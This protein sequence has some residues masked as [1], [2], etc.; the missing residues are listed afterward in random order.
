MS[1]LSKV[2]VVYKKGSTVPEAGEEIES[3]ILRI[4]E[5]ISSIRH[6]YI[7][8]GFHLKEIYRCKYHEKLGYDNFEEFCLCN[9]GMEKS[10]VSR[11]L[12]VYEKF[13]DGDEYKE[14]GQKMWIHPKYKDYSY[15]QLCEMVSMKPE[16]LKKVKPDMSVKSI[17][18][19]KKSLKN[20]ERKEKK[21]NE[22]EQKEQVK[23]RASIISQCKTREDLMRMIAIKLGDIDKSFINVY[24]ILGDQPKDNRSVYINVRKDSK[25]LE[26]G[27]YKLVLQKIKEK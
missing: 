17:R 25:G 3:Y 24:C 10:A 11:C 20:P 5:D 23:P 26:P 2:K 18:E 8:L 1:E 12:N 13:A 7:R 4:H 6:D 16:D 14:T 27:K 22:K 15:S 19:L 21:E 9:Y